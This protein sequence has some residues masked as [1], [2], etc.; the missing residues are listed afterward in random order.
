MERSFAVEWQ[1]C[2][3][4]RSLPRRDR[5]SKIHTSNA[6]SARF[7]ESVSIIWSSSVKIT[8][9][10]PCEITSTIITTLARM[11]HWRETRRLHERSK[12]R[13][14]ARSSQS[15]KSAGCIIVTDEPHNVGDPVSSGMI[16]I[17]SMEGLPA[18]AEIDVRC[19]R[20][21]RHRR[22]LESSIRRRDRRRIIRE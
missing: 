2:R 7:A 10:E 5:L 9:A 13:R 20:A 3:S 17:K 16:L 8:C 11:R 1:G 4:K 22:E 14:R 12:R 21:T 15:L 6:S 19:R 18:R